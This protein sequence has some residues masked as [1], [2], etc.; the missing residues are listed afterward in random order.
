[1]LEVS[2]VLGVDIS[3]SAAGE[4]PNLLSASDSRLELSRSRS[5]EMI[6]RIFCACRNLDSSSSISFGE[7]RFVRLLGPS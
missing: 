4:S 7:R 2:K 3:P 5:G 1:M 6:F